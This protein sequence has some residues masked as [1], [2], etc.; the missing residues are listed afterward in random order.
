MGREE[1]AERVQPVLCCAAS[2]RRCAVRW[3]AVGTVF[4]AVGWPAVM[5]ERI[6]KKK[7]TL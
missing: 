6:E 2:H 5:E 3:A 1:E 4:E 7:K